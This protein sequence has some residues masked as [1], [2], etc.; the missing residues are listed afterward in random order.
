VLLDE[1]GELSPWS[2][3]LLLHKLRSRPPLHGPRFFAS[4]HRDLDALVAAGAFSQE[5]VARLGTA[6]LTLQP[7][8]ERREEI[9]PLALHFL[10]LALRASGRSFVSVDPDLF[11]YL[12]RH[13]WPG[14]AREL[15]NAMLRTLAANESGTLELAD[16]P[17]SVR[18]GVMAASQ[19]SR[20]SNASS[21]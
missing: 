21:H 12:E 11:H 8:R 10:R 1:V 20:A 14:N 16:L 17:D 9:V 5:L 7:L 13:A 2:Q 4:T 19:A 18:L 15:R 3:A 6:R